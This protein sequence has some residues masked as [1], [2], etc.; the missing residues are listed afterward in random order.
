MNPY[1]CL[2]GTGWCTDPEIVIKAIMADYCYCEYSATK[3]YRKTIRSLPYQLMKYTDPM[4]LADVVR[5]D[6]RAL[7]KNHF[8]SVECSVDYVADDQGTLE[9]ESPRF[10]LEVSLIA[11][12]GIK[13]YTLSEIININNAE[14]MTV[15]E[16][17]L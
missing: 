17:V 8:D 12:D 10:R 11:Y 1:P 3:T 15:G 4:A 5:E 14:V 2:N 13:R 9:V 16:S 7:Y 6:L